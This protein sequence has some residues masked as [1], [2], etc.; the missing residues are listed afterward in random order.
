MFSGD[1]SKLAM[2]RSI[3]KKK[4]IISIVNTNTMSSLWPMHSRTCIALLYIVVTCLI[5]YDQ[6]SLNHIKEIIIYIYI[7]I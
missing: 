2:L 7:Y 4:K 3:I 6:K 1:I 5:L